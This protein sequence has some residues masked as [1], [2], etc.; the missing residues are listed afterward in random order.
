MNQLNDGNPETL[1]ADFL[2]EGGGIWKKIM[3]KLTLNNQ[4]YDQWLKRSEADQIN[5]LLDLELFKTS[6][7]ER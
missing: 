3:G 6:S 7:I 4:E 2:V 5:D 1:T